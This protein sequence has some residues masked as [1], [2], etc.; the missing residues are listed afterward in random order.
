MLTAP[1][2]SRFDLFF[3]LIDE[4]NEVVDNAIAK[5]IVELHCNNVVSI[6]TKYS[7][8]EILRYINFAKHFKPCLTPVRFNIK[9]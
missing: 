9:L 6:E 1:I 8:E 4:C 5:K 7:Q 3:I 2:M